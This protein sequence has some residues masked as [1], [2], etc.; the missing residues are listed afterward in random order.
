M[1][2][3]NIYKDICQ[4]VWYVNAIE[5]NGM[6]RSTS[7]YGKNALHLFEKHFMH[8]HHRIDDE[9]F[10]SSFKF[11]VFLFNKRVCF[12]SFSLS[13]C[14]FFFSHNYLMGIKCVKINGLIVTSVTKTW[15]HLEMEPVECQI[16]I[17]NKRVI[18]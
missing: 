10:S 3:L 8:L 12:L 11:N 14:V 5:Y 17:K 18:L 1:E 15:H 13:L 9:Q 16:M 2:M 7:N 4:F 6:T